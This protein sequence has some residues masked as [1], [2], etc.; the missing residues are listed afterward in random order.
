LLTGRVDNGSITGQ[1][2]HGKVVGPLLASLGRTWATHAGGA[3]Q[4]GPVP[5]EVKLGWLV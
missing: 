1:G 5:I 2:K 4:A 3:R